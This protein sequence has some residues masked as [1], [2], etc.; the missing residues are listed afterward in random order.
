[1]RLIESHAACLEMKQRRG[2]AAALALA[3]AAS[4]DDLVAALAAFRKHATLST[5]GRSCLTADG[6]SQTATVAIDDD[7]V[8]NGCRRIVVEQDENIQ[9]DN[10]TKLI[11]GLKR[12]IGGAATPEEALNG[13]IAQAVGEGREVEFG[14]NGDCPLTKRA[15]TG[16]GGNTIGGPQG[17]IS[18]GRYWKQS[19]EASTGLSFEDL[20]DELR[21]LQARIASLNDQS[22]EVQQRCSLTKTE[23]EELGVT[24]KSCADWV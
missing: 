6:A 3:L 9:Q 10:V 19:G 15:Q 18:W 21:I 16:G 14:A 13:A 2:N 12:R 1:M 7:E 4:I 23:S 24:L 22:E 17:T 11:E 5:A 8:L 20:D